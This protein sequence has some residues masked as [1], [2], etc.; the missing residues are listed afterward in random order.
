MASTDK[1]VYPYWR[2]RWRRWRAAH[3]LW[4]ADLNYRRFPSP[5]NGNAYLVAADYL[6]RVEASRP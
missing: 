5:R 3:Y 6:R 1:P 4:A 2:W